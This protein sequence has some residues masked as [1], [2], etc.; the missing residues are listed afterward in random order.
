MKKRRD[1]NEI[2]IKFFI[3]KISLYK[4]MVKDY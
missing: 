3:V 1:E 2:E 4:N